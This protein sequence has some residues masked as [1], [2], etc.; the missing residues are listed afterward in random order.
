MTEPKSYRLQHPRGHVITVLS[1]DRRDIFVRRG[2]TALGEATAEPTPTETPAEQPVK[3]ADLIARAK[4]LGIPA[5][6]TND[7]LQAAIAEAE[8]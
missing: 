1:A 2:Y 4:E 3:R 7:A 8:A 6:G 5:K